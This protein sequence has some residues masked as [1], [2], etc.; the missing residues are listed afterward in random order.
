M[1]RWECCGGAFGALRCYLGSPWQHPNVSCWMGVPA[2]DVAGRSETIPGVFGEGEKLK[3]CFLGI[4]GVCGRGGER[5]GL[6]SCFLG[7]HGV[8]G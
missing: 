1:S 4:P 8:C 2:G 7:I 3:A 6:K 5:G